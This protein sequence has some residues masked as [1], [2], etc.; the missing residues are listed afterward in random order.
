MTKVK[1]TKEFVEKA[2]RLNPTYDYSQ[3][4]YMGSKVAVKI[5]C[6][7]GHQFMQSPNH[8]L[9]GQKCPYCQGV[10]TLTQEEFLEKARAVHGEKY[11]YSKVTFTRIHDKVKIICPI[12][13][14]FEQSAYNHSEGAGCR[15]CAHTKDN[16][17]FKQKLIS[18]YGDKYD[19]SLVEWNGRD[20][21]VK[22]ICPIHGEVERV[23]RYLLRGDC[24]CTKCYKDSTRLTQEEFLEKAKVVHGDAFDYSEVTYVN[25]ITPIKIKCPNGHTFETTPQ[26]HL[27]NAAG[28]S[29]CNSE[30]RSSGERKIRWYLHQHGIKFKEQQTFEGCKYKQKLLFD[31]YIPEYNLCIEFQGEQ[32]Y[33]PWYTEE[34]FETQQI[35]DNIKR[36]F[37]KTHNINLL[38]IRYDEPLNSTLEKALK[39][40]SQQI[41]A[42]EVNSNS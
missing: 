8:H 26:L 27:Y 25:A 12:H 35:R 6:D 41:Y 13:G 36:E 14:E 3:S 16:E 38:E 21:K 39:K 9:R 42:K 33:R 17:E 1:T 4:E 31:F 30:R 18:I 7:K 23:A 5:I 34:D 2:Q 29:I 10:H 19:F 15:R 11:D 37:C 20:A 40:F 22:I 28:C 24:G 32:H